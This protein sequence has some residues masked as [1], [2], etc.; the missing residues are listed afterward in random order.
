V[1]GLDTNVLVRHLVQVDDAAQHAAAEKL[2]SLATADD[3][4]YVSLV[5]VIETVWVLRQGYKYPAD[6]VLDFVAALLRAP[7]V[8]VEESRLVSSALVHARAGRFDLA[9]AV[10]AAAGR[11]AGCSVTYT[12]DRKAVNL[13]GM[14]LLDPDAAFTR[15]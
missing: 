4:V 10:I 3:P 5:S 11:R 12:F 13:P 6:E 1:I 2:L 8:V 9:D 7:E 14:A 15:N